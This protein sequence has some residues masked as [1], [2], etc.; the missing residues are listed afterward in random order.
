MKALTG[1]EKTR[2]WSVLVLAIAA[3]VMTCATAAAQSFE[4]I[5]GFGTDPAAPSRPIGAVVIAADGTLYGVSYD[6]G[7]AGCRTGCGSIYSFKDGVVTT[8]HAFTDG[9]PRGI[10][11]GADGA[12][13]GIVRSSTAFPFGYIFKWQAG[14]FSV[15]HAFTG[16][17]GDGA[18]PAYLANGIDG[19]IYGTTLGG[20]SPN[21]SWGSIFRFQDGTMT[22][23]YSGPSQIEFSEACVVQG[24]DG[25]LYGV[26]TDGGSFRSGTLF[27]LANGALTTLHTFSDR[28]DGSRP[29]GCLVQGSDGAFYGTTRFGGMFGYGTVFKWDGQ[30]TIL[31]DFSGVGGAYPTDGAYPTGSLTQ[32]ADGAFYGITESTGSTTGSGAAGT[33]FRLDAA[34]LTTVHIFFGMSYAVNSDG[35]MPILSLTKGPD[36]A[37]Y[38]AVPGLQGSKG[39]IFRIVLPFPT[40][41]DQCKDGGWKRFAN[42][43]FTNQGQ[44]VSFVAR[45][46]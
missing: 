11:Q 7:T 23:L 34:G 13:Y 46:R 33:V 45:R 3:S 24:A 14:V 44:C 27:R 26:T 43:S 4:I 41:K 16:S 38:G 31:H 36:G 28:P 40:T 29:E 21:R 37:L 10:I 17:G 15:A 19:A 2:R 12:L 20:T 42:P 18:G 6:G 35:S 39:S 25:A 1:R 5:G 32:T 9:Q 22:T 30:L 8:L